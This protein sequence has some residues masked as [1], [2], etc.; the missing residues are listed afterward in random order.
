MLELAKR[1]GFFNTRT[2]RFIARMRKFF[3]DESGNVQV[4]PDGT[5]KVVASQSTGGVEYQKVLIV[6]AITPTGSPS[7]MGNA[8][9]L[10]AKVSTGAQLMV[11]PGDWAQGHTPA[12]A[13]QA[14]T[15]KAAGAAGVCHVCTSITCVVSTV[16]TAQTAALVFVLRDGATGA[17]TILWT[18]QVSLPVSYTQVVTI[19]GLNIIGTAATAMT[20]ETVAAPAAAAFAS[21]SMTGYDTPA[22]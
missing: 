17:G 7:L 13:T 16:G 15:S 4:P 10:S 22:A 21:V 14:T 6:D 11:R 1:E 3:P 9:N 18:F 12:A 20:L 5:G 19:S 2:A 8:A